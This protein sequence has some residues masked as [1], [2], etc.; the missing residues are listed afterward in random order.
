MCGEQV[1]KIYGTMKLNE[2]QLKNDRVHTG[3]F[4]SGDNQ[5]VRMQFFS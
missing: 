2:A 4:V 3:R 5:I 1:E